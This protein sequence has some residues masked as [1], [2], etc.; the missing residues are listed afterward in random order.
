MHVLRAGATSKTTIADTVDIGARLLHENGH[1]THRLGVGTLDGAVQERHGQR[2]RLVGMR[3]LN[4][5]AH[6]VHRDACAAPGC[7]QVDAV[8]ARVNDLRDDLFVVASGS[9][10]QRV[11]QHGLRHAILPLARP[12]K[13]LVTILVLDTLSCCKYVRQ[14]RATT[15]VTAQHNEALPHLDGLGHVLGRGQHAVAVVEALLDGGV[16]ARA[17]QVDADGATAQSLELGKREPLHAQILALVIKVVRI[18]HHHVGAEGKHEL[19]VG[20]A[21]HEPGVG[22]QQVLPADDAALALEDGGLEPYGIHLVDLGTCDGDKTVT[23]GHG[24]VLSN[25]KR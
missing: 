11:S 1:L 22:E 21:P 15:R 4:Q 6:H 24:G 13:D 16:G 23:L 3:E 5:L 20:H 9:L 7:R 2:S 18:E 25:G 8:G 10:G 12:E 17:A 14:A 19:R